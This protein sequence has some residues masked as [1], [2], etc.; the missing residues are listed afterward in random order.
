M[1]LS[2]EILADA[3]RNARHSS[4]AWQDVIAVTRSGPAVLMMTFPDGVRLV[5]IVSEQEMPGQI[6][7]AVP[8][9]SGVL[10]ALEQIKEGSLVL[11]DPVRSRVLVEPDATEIALLQTSTH[12]ARFRLG[13]AHIP[14]TTQ[15]GRVVST[16]ALVH[17]L[18]DV[19]AALAGGADGLFIPS[20][21]VLLTPLAEENTG[22][23]LRTLRMVS[24]AFGGGDMVLS[25]T[26]EMFAPLTLARVGAFSLLRIAIHPTDLPLPPED[27]HFELEKIVQQEHQA[28]RQAGLF[29]IGALGPDIHASETAEFDEIYL[30]AEF[31]TQMTPEDLFSL[32]P[33]FALFDNPFDDS[34]TGFVGAIAAGAAGVVVP[35]VRVSE[36][37]HL[38]REQE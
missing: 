24:D 12:R 31:V 21:S 32:P 28:L 8:V 36:A 16:L 20:S 9:V 22:E 2:P 18:S 5:G 3:D 29:G 19:D 30:G 38:I 23:A 10:G 25:I 13:A 35:A 34:L 6:T 26:A 4:D 27:V 7:T 33:M 11:L 1:T 17:E 37:K 14:A 15:G